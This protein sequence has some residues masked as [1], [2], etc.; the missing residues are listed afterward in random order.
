MVAQK[1]DAAIDAVEL[2]ENAF[3]QAKS[4]FGKSPWSERLHIINA[5]VKHFNSNH[6]YDLIISNP[7][8]FEEEL[9]SPKE[10]V[11]LARHDSGLSLEELLSIVNAYLDTDGIFAVLLPYKRV[12]YFEEAA[13]KEGLYVFDK[14]LVRQTPTHPPFRVLLL[15]QRRKMVISKEEITIKNA[16]GNYNDEFSALLKDYYLNL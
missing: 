12:T 4:N 8:F 1:S 9:R 11:N 5:D 16:E 3:E 10:G 13:V 7:P 2:E 15:L 14:I 6:R